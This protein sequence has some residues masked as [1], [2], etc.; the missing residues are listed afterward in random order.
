MPTTHKTATELVHRL[1][2]RALLEMR[3]QGREQ[4]NKLVYH[5]ADLFHNA[6]LDMEAAAEGRS[7]YDDVLRLLDEKARETNCERWLQS[8]LAEIEVSQPP[9]SDA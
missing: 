9:K 6:V 7:T 5:L 1:L 3:E 8:A 2:L 4:K